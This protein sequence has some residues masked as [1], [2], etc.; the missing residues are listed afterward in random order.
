M[1]MK[2]KLLSGSWF[3]DLL[4]TF[5]PDKPVVNGTPA[6][7]TRTASWK[8]FGIS[9]AAAIPPGPLGWATIIPE[10]LTVTK[11]QINL[12]YSIA[13]FHKKE[14]QMNQTLL[15]LIFA[16]EA[17]IETGRSIVKK[18]GSKVVIKKV[19]VIGTATPF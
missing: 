13:A 18:Y 14:S 7:M 16:N 4:M 12:I 6:E 11:I 2:E 5:A 1:D 10:M 19:M 15:M 9:T 8:A 17:G 3:S